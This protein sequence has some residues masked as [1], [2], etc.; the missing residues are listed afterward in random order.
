MKIKRYITI[1][2]IIFA[3]ILLTNSYQV[4]AD[5]PNMDG[6]GSGGGTQGGSSDNY[7]SSDD[8]GIRLTVIDVNTGIRTEGTHTIDY[9]RKNKDGKKIIHF[10]KVCKLEYMGVSGYQA[11]KELR[12]SSE[13][14]KRND[15]GE[16]VAFQV[17]E[18]PIIVSSSKGNSDIEEIKRY[19]NNEDRLRKV[20]SRVGMSYDELISGRYKL[21]I[22]PVIYLTFNSMYMAMTAHEAAKLD[23]SLGGTSTTGGQLRA[24]FVSFTHKNLP[25]SIFLKK[26]ELGVK[27]WTGSKYDRVNNDQILT[28]LGIGILSFE[29]EDLETDVD[30]VDFDYRP[31]TDVITYVDVS[32]GNSGDG[33]TSDNPI[34][35]TFSGDLIGTKVVTGI[36]IPPGG[37]R[38]VWIKWHTP[39]VK[40]PDILASTINV[41]VTG[42]SASNATIKVKIKPIARIEPPNPTADDTKKSS[43]TD[44]ILPDFPKLT[45]LKSYTE[46]VTSRSWRT[47]TCTKKSVW[48]GDYYTDEE[49]I[50]HK[51]YETVYE[52]NENNYTAAITAMKAAITPDTT[53]R[54]SNP[55]DNII[56]S[57]YGIELKVSSII[58]GSSSSITGMQNAVVYFPEFEYKWFRRIGT[59]PGAD[60]N[61]IIEFPVNVFSI[62]GSKIH[63]LPIWFPDKEYKVYIET[64]DAWTPAGMLCDKTTASINVEGSL[65]DDYH[66][67][68]IPDI[69]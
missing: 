48:L 14:Y 51:I 58:S 63:F 20:A 9:Y 41:A 66:L 2:M 4:K 6:G 45:E 5:D 61:D 15:A 11:A 50:E 10:G 8:D 46:P 27:N 33:A 57:G 67:G 68:V 34:T 28:Y 56:K 13:D 7:Y 64:I 21:I 52:F 49:G 54:K 31:D 37:S 62:R 39:K 30:S 60:L 59:T 22:E 36:V 19:F 18:M 1:I 65:W 53:V 23:M 69:Y 3:F 12:Q 40:E 35:V 25:L 44:R 43:W 47:Y 55:D 32:V 16:T 29:S 38:P 42:G 26:K 24:K 17:E